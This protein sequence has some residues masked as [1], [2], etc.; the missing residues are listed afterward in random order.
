VNS[1]RGARK[2]DMVDLINELGDEINR[3]LNTGNKQ[4]Y[5]ECVILLYSFVENLLVWLLYVKTLWEM[6][7]KPAEISSKELDDTERFFQR[8]SFYNS[9][10]MALSTKL[11]DLDL[12]RRIDKLRKE[13]NNMIHQ[14]WLYEHRGD[15]SQLR[16]KLE[17]LASA[18]N[19]LVSI[20]KRLTKKVGVDEVYRT[21]LGR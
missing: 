4:R 12:W 6:H 17:E 7:S 1:K 13:R 14:L 16:K 9:T 2:L 11:I 15:T 21:I 5:F 10:W 18:A 8:L 19:D 20:F 3:V